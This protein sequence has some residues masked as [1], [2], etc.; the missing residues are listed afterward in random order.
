M[1]RSQNLVDFMAGFLWI[2]L[3]TMFLLP[4]I[5]LGLFSR[6]RVSIFDSLK[7]YPLS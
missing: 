3:F 6:R 4:I 5:S 2:N 7:K 1:Y